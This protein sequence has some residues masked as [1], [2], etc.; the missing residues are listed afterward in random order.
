MENALLICDSDKGI[1][2]FRNFLTQNFGLKVTVVS[3]GEE[4]RQILINRDFDL[5]FINCPLLSE[6]GEELAISIAEKNISQVIMAVKAEQMDEI[7]AK[8]EDFGIITVS[9]PISKAL[10][11]NALK[12][13][14]VTQNRMNMLR[15]ENSKLQQRLEDIKL[16]NHAKNVLISY[17]GI[18][19]DEAHKYI[20]KRAMD[21]RLQ[22]R[23]IAKEVLST[24]ER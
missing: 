5:C 19:E 9:K 10:L 23:D 2:Y 21:M 8:V 17:L 14:S 13:A 11:W 4:A 12:L 15:S 6:F 3:G 22:K 1:E 24:Y 18:S 16:I 20:E 7:A